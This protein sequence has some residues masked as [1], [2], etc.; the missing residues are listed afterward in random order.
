MIGF[1]LIRIIMNHYVSTIQVILTP[2]VPN[3]FNS[4]LSHF[5][6]KQILIQQKFLKDM[7]YSLLAL[8]TAIGYTI[9]N[10]QL[11]EHRYSELHWCFLS[12]VT[13]YISKKYCFFSWDLYLV[14]L[15]YNLKHSSKT[16]KLE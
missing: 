1:Y 11:K 5:Q 13:S 12:V 6:Q 9:L 14:T 10:L 4:H 3:T 2:S 8:L 15:S 16:N 7:G